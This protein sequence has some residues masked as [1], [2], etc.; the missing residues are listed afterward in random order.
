MEQKQIAYFQ[1]KVESVFICLYYEKWYGEDI[2]KQTK[3]SDYVVDH[4][5][6]N[7][8]LLR[9]CKSHYYY[10]RQP[11]KGMEETHYLLLLKLN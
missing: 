4:M 5:D 11:E 3:T 2:Y 6:N 10:L 9:K 7:G 1:S 8:E